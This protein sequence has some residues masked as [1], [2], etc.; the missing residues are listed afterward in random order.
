MT[1]APRSPETRTAT[2]EKQ[3]DDPPP[4][5]WEEHYY[6]IPAGLMLLLF[7]AA[8]FRMGGETD[9]ECAVWAIV[10]VALSVAVLVLGGGSVG[11]ILIQV[12]LLVLAATVGVIRGERRE[13]RKA[14]SG[15]A[16]SAEEMSD[17]DPDG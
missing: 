4:T 15:P 9:R 14:A 5:H 7:A 2:L 12:P 6:Y 10:S 1:R 17:G 11:I 16:P 8:L 3:A 13:R